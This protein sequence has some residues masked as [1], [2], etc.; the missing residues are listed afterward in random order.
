MTTLSLSRLRT[1]AAV[2]A[3]AVLALSI[4]GAVVSN[5]AEERLADERVGV[6][7]HGDAVVYE[8]D[9]A[10]AA[11]P[12]RVAFVWNGTTQIPWNDDLIVVDALDLASEWSNAT[13]LFAGAATEAVA[14]IGTR[15]SG[16]SGA[17]T[18]TTPVGSTSHSSSHEEHGVEYMT[19]QGAADALCFARAGWQGERLA[20]LDG[21][22]GARFCRGLGNATL[23][24]A[25]WDRV[26][27]LDAARFET[28]MFNV[29][30][31]LWLAPGLAYPVRAVYETDD[32]NYRSSRTLVGYEGGDGSLVP[33]TPAAPPLAAPAAALGA[34][35]PETMGAGMPGYTLGAAVRAIDSDTRLSR[36]PAWRAAHPDAQLMKAWLLRYP[37]SLCP[38]AASGRFVEQWQL[39]FAAGDGT[40]IGLLSERRQTCLGTP[41]LPDALAP[42]TSALV[43]NSEGEVERGLPPPPAAS[44]QAVRF[45]YLASLLGPDSAVETYGFLSFPVPQLGAWVGGEAFVQTRPEEGEP[46]SIYADRATGAVSFR[47]WWRN[48]R[49]E[50]TGTGVF[51]LVHPPPPPGASAP[52]VASTTAATIP[53][54]VYFTTGGL[55]AL[56]LLAALAGGRLPAAAVLAYTRLTRGDVLAN[57]ARAAI[58]AAAK[59]SPGLS[60]A[61]ARSAAGLSHGGAAYHLSVL[62][63]A[64]HLARLESGGF[65]RY[66]V[67]GSADFVRFAEE[68]VLLTG[69]AE[70]RVLA[71][72]RGAP[73]STAADLARALGV[74]RVA[75][76]YTLRRLEGRGLVERRREGARVLV[77]AR[78]P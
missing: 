65:T 61:D 41:A 34:N 76:H 62:V 27:D 55:S 23:R 16:G 28:K 12:T 2:T 56:V 53:D 60:F 43:S 74:S 72:A 37:D 42:A 45:A 29:T 36:Y 39:Q 32:G 77:V 54:G 58:L 8:V 25:G 10:D 21:A 50:T 6:P 73:G 59:A 48:V 18:V 1:I 26:A 63:R 46:S 4:A 3:A 57:P 67:A 33:A 78:G 71:A 5:E 31:S 68:A 17:S 66:F 35:D 69:G 11:G 38:Q 40:A 52:V 70:A 9:G 47:G 7:R 20:A 64:G 24:A 14:S 49:A 13:Y 30:F 75:V 51:A 22:P 44:P 19:G 15:S